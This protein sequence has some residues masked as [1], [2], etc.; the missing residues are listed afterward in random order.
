MKTIFGFIGG[1]IVAA[2]ILLVIVGFVSLFFISHVG[3]TH[4]THNVYVTAVETNGIIWSTNR[5]YVKTSQQSSQEDTY[6]VK[7][8]AVLAQLKDAVATG[9]DVVITYDHPLVEW[10]WNCDNE[11]A[12]ITAVN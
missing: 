6:C 8:A 1:L 11:D 7:D 5:A 9:K 3:K 4:G 12:I 2:V 10:I